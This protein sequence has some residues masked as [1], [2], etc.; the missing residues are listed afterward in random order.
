MEF[1]PK[2]QAIAVQRQKSIYFGNEGNFEAYDI[3]SKPIP[4][5]IIYEDVKINI[6]NHNPLIQ[7]G[8]VRVIAISSSSL[9][10]IGTNQRIE[11]E[12]RI[13]H[14]RQLTQP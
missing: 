6:R 8:N 9:V 5:P 12:A 4:L 13:K 11:S 7:V 3:F 2:T 10:Q 1:K 14:I